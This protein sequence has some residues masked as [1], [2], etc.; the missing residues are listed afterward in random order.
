MKIPWDF[1]RILRGIVSESVG[2]YPTEFLG[3]S[4]GI[5]EKKIPNGNPVG[6]KKKKNSVQTEISWD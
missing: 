4:L 5:E 3:K 1:D 2:F 6:L